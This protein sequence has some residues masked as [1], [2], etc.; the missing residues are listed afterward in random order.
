MINPVQINI[1][2][3][4]MTKIPFKPGFLTLK[5]ITNAHAVINITHAYILYVIS[6]VK[7]C[8]NKQTAGNIKDDL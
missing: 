1:P 3:T 7:K 2:T 5:L 4:N 6:T 8:L